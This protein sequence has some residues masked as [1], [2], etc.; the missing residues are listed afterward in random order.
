MKKH[1]AWYLKAEP[2]ELDAIWN[3]GI[4]TVDANVLLDLYRFHASTRDSL[5]ECLVSFSGRLWLSHQA[6]EEFFTNRAK[7]IVDSK[8]AFANAAKALATLRAALSTADS[9]LRSTR[10][11]PDEVASTLQSSLSLSISTAEQ[12][13]ENASQEYPDFL[14]ED[15]VLTRLC[16]LFDDAIGDPF[17]L[18][19]REE[20]R[21]EAERRVNTKVPPG[22]LDC[23][24]GEESSYGDFF[25]WRQV[26]DHAKQAKSSVIFVTSEQKEDWWE[27][28]SGKTIGPRS[29]LLKEASAYS[30]QRILIYKT[31]TFVELAM[32][33]NVAGRNT[34]AIDEIR[35][36][37]STRKVAAESS[38]RLHAQV[39]TAEGRNF[40]RGNV[41]FQVLSPIA[42]L[43]IPIGYH[44][45]FSRGG[46]V[47][48][49]VEIADA[50][51]GCPAVGLTAH[52][53]SP[54][55][56]VLEVTTIDEREPLP[57]GLYAVE[58]L[59]RRRKMWYAPAESERPAASDESPLE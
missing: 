17:P 11:L 19:V 32:A 27:R 54:D 45:A 38:V 14:S 6:A 52:P 23:D 29:E 56:C 46:Q 49:D 44:F 57:V 53:Q 34:R 59:V 5:L 47:E 35:E 16:K 3:H 41:T 26:L 51:E 18:E 8:R 28:Y 42:R 37:S 22:Y 43:T 15:P 30:G 9:T 40:C 39:M 2:A 55:T 33:K 50:P 20:I 58:Y 4:L 12:Q 1:F 25:V 7:V 31:D 21:K 24:K 10:I 36:V 48:I 13:V